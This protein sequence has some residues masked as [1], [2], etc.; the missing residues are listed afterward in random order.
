MK[1]FV[2]NIN[3]IFEAR[4]RALRTEKAWSQEY[5]AFDCGLHWTYISGVER[6]E[7]NISLK[8][9]KKIAGKFRIDIIELF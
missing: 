8:N 3:K 6:G 2:N 1:A 7:R 4:V 9:I 5:F